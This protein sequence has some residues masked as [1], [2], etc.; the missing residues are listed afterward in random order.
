MW[1]FDH[2]ESIDDILN[3][4]SDMLCQIIT[5]FVPQSNSVKVLGN[6]G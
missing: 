1:E 3:L 5:N 4:F 2:L 6:R